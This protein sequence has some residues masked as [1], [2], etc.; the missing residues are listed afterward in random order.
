MTDSSSNTKKKQNSSTKHRLY[1]RCLALPPPKLPLDAS[2]LSLTG[3][4]G[5]EDERSEDL[6]S[7]YSPHFLSSL[8]L[9]AHI[10]VPLRKAL[11]HFYMSYRNKPVDK[12]EWRTLLAFGR[13]FRELTSSPSVSGTGSVA[14][15]A[16]SMLS[17]ISSTSDEEEQQEEHRPVQT[18]TFFPIL[19]QCLL[20]NKYSTQPKDATEALQI[21][22]QT[23]QS[24]VRTIPVT[25]ELWTA[26]LDKACLGLMVQQNLVGRRNKPFQKEDNYI[27]Q[28]TNK[29]KCLLWCPHTLLISDRQRIKQRQSKTNADQEKIEGEHPSPVL[30]PVSL[31]QLLEVDCEKRPIETTP[32]NYHDFEKKNSYT[33]EVKIPLAF[34]SEKDKDL[35]KTTTGKLWT[36]TRSMVFD[37]VTGYL[38]LGL[39]RRGTNTHSKTKLDR[40]EIDIPSQLDISK[41]VSPE[42][43]KK[44]QNNAILYELIGGVLYDD[45]DYVAVLRD[46]AREKKQET[47]NS[48]NND[49]S[50]NS[51]DTKNENEKGEEE[52][53]DEDDEAWKL[54]ESEEVIPMS[55]SDV[56]EFLKG[57]GNDE[58]NNDDSDVDSD[59]EEFGP[60]GTMAVYK[61]VAS[62]LPSSSS[63]SASK[64]LQQKPKVFEEMNTLLSDIILSQVSGKLEDTGTTEYYIEEEIIEE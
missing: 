14:S 29:E 48:R 45:G 10:I 23:I 53:D 15:G 54:M 31:Q 20:H 44:Y 2:L 38:F 57:E 56:L 17:G 9:L 36:T 28:R 41:L 46:P 11:V 25:N 50:S 63:S 12:L 33:F 51:S 7:S 61:L 4:G 21:I 37:T 8:Q 59:E 6:Q 58:I 35:T 52:Y 13:L 16:R 3:T 60:C 18:E 1:F 55:E 62:P 39:Q 32:R 30:P 49:T 47:N 34:M 24:C 40:T 19:Y 64:Q 5:A 42:C 43:K 22:L 27:I 26:L